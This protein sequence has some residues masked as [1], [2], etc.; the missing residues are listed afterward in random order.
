MDEAK[1]TVLRVKGPFITSSCFRD[2]VFDVSYAIHSREKRSFF[3]FIKGKSMSQRTFCERLLYVQ[4]KAEKPSTIPPHKS[5]AKEDDTF[6][7]IFVFL[8]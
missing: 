1:K 8:C 7:R 3:F 6:C 5:D 4:V 2:V